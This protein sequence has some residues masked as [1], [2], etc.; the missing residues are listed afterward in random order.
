MKKSALVS[1]ESPSNKK[2]NVESEDGKRTES[3][4]TK[5][6]RSKF[7]SEEE[8]ESVKEMAKSGGEE[9][10][11][12]PMA[13]SQ[14]IH[15][16]DE[17]MLQVDTTTSPTEN[18]PTSS[19]DGS[20]DVE[21]E[22]EGP[23]PTDAKYQGSLSDDSEASHSEEEEKSASPIAEPPRRRK[24]NRLL[25]KS[26]LKKQCKHSTTIIKVSDDEPDSNEEDDDEDTND[27]N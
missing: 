1:Q 13:N 16:D 15:S 18:A 9:E 25:A 11:A 6:S 21:S 5:P 7:S 26:V 19:Y 4:K 12:S 14:S 22:E 27:E 20:K 24:S 3:P 17:E 2:E 8:A 23:A 10:C